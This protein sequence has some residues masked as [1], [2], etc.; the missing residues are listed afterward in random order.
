MMKRA[1][2]I[3][4]LMHY[5]EVVVARGAVRKSL[6]RD[7]ITTRFRRRNFG[8]LSDIATTCI[9]NHIRGNAPTIRDIEDNVERL[10]NR[11]I[12]LFRNVSNYSDSIFRDSSEGTN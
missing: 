2:C 5:S 12:W 4:I 11:A 1:I 8:V 10:R 9:P 6:R 3:I 7:I